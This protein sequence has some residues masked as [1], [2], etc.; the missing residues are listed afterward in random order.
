[1]GDVI[2]VSLTIPR[3]C[4]ISLQ[5][6][7]DRPTLTRTHTDRHTPTARNADAEIEV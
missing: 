6:D 5:S 4:S 1:M 2:L 3:S 7:E